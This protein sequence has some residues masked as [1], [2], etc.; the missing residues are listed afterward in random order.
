VDEAK[1]GFAVIE[2]SLWQAIPSHLRKVDA[3]LF[4]ATGLRL[5][6]EARRSASPRGWAATVTATPMSPPA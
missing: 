2:H 4:Q 1:W 3:A 5:P 6:L